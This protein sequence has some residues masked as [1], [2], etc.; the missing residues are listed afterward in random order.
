LAQVPVQLVQQPALR[1][2]LQVPVWQQ[3]LL[4]PV[5]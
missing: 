1:R 5:P 4:Q 2:P 3:E